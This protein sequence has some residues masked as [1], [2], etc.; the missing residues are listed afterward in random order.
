MM[1]IDA[2]I[3]RLPGGGRASSRSSRWNRIARIAAVAA[4]QTR[5]HTSRNGSPNS[6]GRT[7]ASEP[8]AYIPTNGNAA[9]NSLSFM[10]ASPEDAYA[11]GHQ[12]FWRMPT[13][14]ATCEVVDDALSVPSIHARP[15]PD[16]AFW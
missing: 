13:T 7:S 1:R 12:N 8:P 14:T 6:S 4:I 9:S 5:L 15:T 10:S 16:D 2:F 3:A 11:S